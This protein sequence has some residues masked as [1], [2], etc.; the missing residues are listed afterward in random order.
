MWQFLSNL[1]VT[2]RF[3]ND[4][5]TPAGFATA[6]EGD[7]MKWTSFSQP[8]KSVSSC[9]ISTMLQGV[10]TRCV[11]PAISGNFLPVL[12][13]R[14][15]AGRTLHELCIILTAGK[16]LPDLQ[17]LHY[18]GRCLYEVGISRHIRKCPS[19]PAASTLCCKEA[20][21]GA[22]CSL[23]R[24]ILPVL[25]HRHYAA[26]RLH[27]VRVVP[28]SRKVLPVLQYHPYARRSLDNVVHRYLLGKEHLTL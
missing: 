28:H 14:H 9:G 2:T 26:K 5:Y 24:K 20:S 13:H 6:P 12:R 1:T 21:Q 4:A 19:R 15:S 7:F 10:Y 25:Q 22:C 16:F 18:T 8:E 11:S 3:Q 27:K 17:C 23:T